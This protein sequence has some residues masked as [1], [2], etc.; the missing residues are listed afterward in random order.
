MPR[1]DCTAD[2]SKGY[3]PFRR[4]FCQGH[5]AWLDPVNP[6][7][8]ATVLSEFAQTTKLPL[9]LQKLLSH[10]C[11]FL[12]ASRA[13]YQPLLAFGLA[14]IETARAVRFV[15]QIFT[16]SIIV[17]FTRKSNFVHRAGYMPAST[18]DDFDEFFT[19]VLST[20]ADLRETGFGD[21]RGEVHYDLD[22]EAS[23][24][25]RSN[26][27]VSPHVRFFEVPT[28]GQKA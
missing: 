10:L 14:K 26:S 16:P 21:G 17:L 8:P 25:P 1:A 7:S 15:H 18:T 19:M 6:V 5:P 20:A 27:L 4:S 22:D 3:S 24:E 12:G 11:Q 13:R 2:V 28:N 9:T 23:T